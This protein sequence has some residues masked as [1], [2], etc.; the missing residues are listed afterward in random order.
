M[1]LRLEEFAVEIDYW[2]TGVTNGLIRTER[3]DGVGLTDG[4]VRKQIIYIFPLMNWC[5]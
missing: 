2:G 5:N 4:L 3:I 1:H